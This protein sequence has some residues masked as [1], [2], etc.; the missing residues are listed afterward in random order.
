MGVLSWFRRKPTDGPSGAGADDPVAAGAAGQEAAA[1]AAG[2]EAAAGAAG[3]E[4]A[5]QETAA[6]GP[7]AAETAPHDAA[8][9]VDSAA[10]C[11]A[12]ADGKT[13]E[14]GVGNPEGPAAVATKTDGAP[15]EPR[16]DV[17]IPQQQSAGEAAATESG[18][19]A[20]T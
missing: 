13:P 12:E 18:D 4:A 17:G 11:A 3:Q 5:E 19:G 15:G 7:G 14:D 16:E 8:D 9:H 2:Q 20:R 10:T 1:G 6:E